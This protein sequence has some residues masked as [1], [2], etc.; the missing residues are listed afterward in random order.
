MRITFN[1]SRRHATYG[2]YLKQPMLMC[3]VKLNQLLYKNTQLIKSLNRFIIYP[4]IQEYA[5]I[6]AGEKYII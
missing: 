6:P 1:S 4:F 5:N 3:E 2:F